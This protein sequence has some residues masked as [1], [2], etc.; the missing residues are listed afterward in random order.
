MAENN[1]LGAPGSAVSADAATLKSAAI[2]DTFQVE[3][4]LQKR[5]HPS[6]RNP[7]DRSSWSDVP[8]DCYL[9]L[10]P[11]IECADGFVMS[12]QTGPTHYCRPRDGRGPWYLFEIGYPS[13]RVDALMPYI[14]GADSDPT[15]TVYG[16]V[17]LH[18]VVQVICD[19]GGM[20]PV[21]APSASTKDAGQSPGID[22]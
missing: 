4:E 6:V 12:V 2:T 8:G 10:I 22:Q 11:R 21:G 19:A 17:P 3:V 1:D 5:L 20:L 7:R 16:Y 13:R 9:D 15:D 18:T 14:D